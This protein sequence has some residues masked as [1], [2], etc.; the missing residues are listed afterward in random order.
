MSKTKTTSIKKE[1][2]TKV[3][4]EQRITPLADRVLIRPLNKDEVEKKTAFGIILPNQDDE[5]KVK[6]QGIV[7]AVGEGKYDDGKLNKMTVKIG[8]RV[9]FSK[10]GFDEVKVNGEEFYIIKEEHILAIIK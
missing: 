2:K 9:L 3:S 6:D 7:V 1:K 5:E 8:D 4:D 10:Y